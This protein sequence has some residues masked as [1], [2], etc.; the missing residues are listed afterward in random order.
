MIEIHTTSQCSYFGII[1]RAK[2]RFHRIQSSGYS[3]LFGEGLFREHRKPANP[4]E[5][6]VVSKAVGESGLAGHG[7][8]GDR[9][10]PGIQ[11]EPVETMEE[12]EFHTA[13]SQCLIQGRDHDVAHPGRHLPE[14][15]SPVTEENL[16]NKERHHPGTN[17]G[18]V[19][20][21]FAV[22]EYQVMHAA[23]HC[24]IKNV[25]MCAVTKDPVAEVLVVDGTEAAGIGDQLVGDDAAYG[26]DHQRNQHPT[27]PMVGSI[28]RVDGVADRMKRVFEDI[29]SGSVTELRIHH[30]QQCCQ[31][32]PHRRVKRRRKR[33]RRG[34]GRHAEH[35]APRS[36]VAQRVGEGKHESQGPLDERGRGKFAARTIRVAGQR[37]VARVRAMPCHPVAVPPVG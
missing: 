21:A 28:V 34:I 5:G 2:M 22:T 9:L 23:H 7:Y 10:P 8:R 25:A 33:R 1:A 6:L 37:V 16:A 11:V 15:R 30:C 18:P 14:N 24:G 27:A 19:R 12:L 32:R 3:E 36:R 13:P 35:Q 20:I 4:G 17:R 29:G 26:S 31:C